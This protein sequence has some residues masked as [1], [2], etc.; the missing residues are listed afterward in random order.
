MCY[1][2]SVGIRQLRQNA[3]AI[4]RRVLEG[5]NIDVTD[6]GRPVARIVPLREVGR[7]D[8][9]ILDGRATGV[10]GELL[11]RKPVPPGRRKPLLSEI[12]ADMRLDER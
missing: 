12:L 3:S 10:R 5:E 1:M 2:A 6:R 7:L 8:Q 9:L 11:D 4:I